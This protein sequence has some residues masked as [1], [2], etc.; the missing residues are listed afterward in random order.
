LKKSFS[1]SFLVLSC[2]GVFAIS[3]N[4]FGAQS[5]AAR[6]RPVQKTKELPAAT[7]KASTPVGPLPKPNEQAPKD[8]ANVYTIDPDLSVVTVRMTHSVLGRFDTDAK[9]GLSGTLILSDD[10]RVSAQRIEFK[11][12]SLRS[13]IPLRDDHMKNDYL[14]MQKYPI[15]VLTGMQ[16]R[17]SS[18]AGHSMPFSGTLIVKGVASPVKGSAKLR[19]VQ[20]EILRGTVEFDTKVSAFPIKKPD[21]KGVG[22]KDEF[23]ILVDL[24]ARPDLKEEQ[25][26]GF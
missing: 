14:E 13:L 23:K 11:V 8:D 5:I 16:T 7:A 9:Q 20:D 21:Y 25:V 26:E 17:L 3:H 10:G 2:I 4:S 18:P 6:S 12:A 24:Y 15:V 19:L 22:V 1:Q